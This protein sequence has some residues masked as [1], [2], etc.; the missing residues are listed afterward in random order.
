MSRPKRNDTEPTRA[1]MR[2]L[3]ARYFGTGAYAVLEE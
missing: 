3:G 1:Y 2:R